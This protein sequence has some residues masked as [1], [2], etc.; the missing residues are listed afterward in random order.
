MVGKKVYITF[1]Q[2]HSYKISSG[3]SDI[4][5]KI[6]AKWNWFAKT[7]IGSQWVNATDSI[8]ANIAE[9]FGRFHKKDKQKF[10]YNARGSAFE[11]LHWAK[12][13]QQR[14]IITNEE[15]M[16]ILKEL[17]L[18]PRE[19]NTLILLTERTLKK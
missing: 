8:A 1:D 3:V 19:I 5:W 13:A 15:S 16:Q 11:S 12:K 9:G 17:E 6:V 2:V 18:L 7:T 4:V 14:N 10:Y